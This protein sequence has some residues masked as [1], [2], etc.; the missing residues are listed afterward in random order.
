MFL[1][2]LELDTSLLRQGTH[3]TVA[4]SH[5]SIIAP[6]LLGAGARAVALPAAVEQRRALHGLRAVHGRLDVGHRVPG[7]RAHP[8]RP[9]ACTRSRMGV[10]ALTCAAVDDVTAWCLLAFVVERRA[11]AA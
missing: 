3:V 4:I 9:R 2:G 1:V 8:D 10:I 5:A 7:A 11:R 6:F